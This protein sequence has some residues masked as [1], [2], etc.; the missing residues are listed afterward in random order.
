MRVDPQ[1]AETTSVALELPKVGPKPAPYATNASPTIANF[2]Q[3][4]LKPATPSTPVRPSHR[5]CKQRC[6]SIGMLDHC[7]PLRKA[8]PFESRNK[9]LFRANRQTCTV[10]FCLAAVVGA[11]HEDSRIEVTRG[12]RRL[13]CICLA[14]VL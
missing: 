13:E 3:R 5:T 2:P 7:G 14:A 4:D 8:T 10:Y 1:I 12:S 11:P 9:A 6:V